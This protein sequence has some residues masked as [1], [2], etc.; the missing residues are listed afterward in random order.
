MR[1]KI[2]YLNKTKELGLVFVKDGDR[3]LSVHVDAYN[4][5]K[6]NDRPSVSGVVVILG[7]HSCD[8]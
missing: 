3:K 6:D 8:C 5:N 2:A 1:D 4:G 7:G